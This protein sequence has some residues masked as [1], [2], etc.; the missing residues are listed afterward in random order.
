LTIIALTIASG[1]LLPVTGYR[2]MKG[3]ALS[4]SNK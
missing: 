3:A 4:R 2:S 1:S